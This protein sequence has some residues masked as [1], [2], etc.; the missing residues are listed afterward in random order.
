MEERIALLRP[1]PTREAVHCPYAA[2]LDLMVRTDAGHRRLRRG[3]DR[4]AWRD[5][6]ANQVHVLCGHY[7]TR[8]AIVDMGLRRLPHLVLDHLRRNVVI[9][10]VG[11]GLGGFQTTLPACPEADEPIQVIA[12]RGDPDDSEAFFS[13]LGHEI[14]HAWLE[15]PHV[16]APTAA[17]LHEL[18]ASRQLSAKLASEWHLRE[19][20]LK[21]YRLSEW[22]AGALA[23]AWGFVGY[24]ADPDACQRA[25]RLPGDR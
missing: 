23:R 18:M 10:A 9:V 3:L 17:Q 21:P 7:T 4:G 22:R 13:V 16:A 25:A 8:T 24:G 19:A 12:L 15:S 2:A 20:A 11:N 6:D 5:V 1:M 14:G